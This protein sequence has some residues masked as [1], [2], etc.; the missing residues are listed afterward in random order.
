MDTPEPNYEAAFQPS[1]YHHQYIYIFIYIYI[2]KRGGIG[3]VPAVPSWGSRYGMRHAGFHRCM[4]V[5]AQGAAPEVA[6]VGIVMRGASGGFTV[7]LCAEEVVPL[8]SQQCCGGRDT[9][10]ARGLM[11]VV[12]GGYGPRLHRWIRGVTGAGRDWRGSAR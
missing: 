4:G 5:A 3:G 6:P 2:P 10:A 11:A 12:G 1:D 9:G 8:W 7:G